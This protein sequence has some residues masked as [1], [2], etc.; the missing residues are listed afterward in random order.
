[1]FELDA[2]SFESKDNA[3]GW[4]FMSSILPPSIE[5][6]LSPVAGFFPLLFWLLKFGTFLLILQVELSSWIF[7]FR[8]FV[9]ARRSSFLETDF[10]KLLRELARLL[11]FDNRFTELFD[12]LRLAVL[13]FSFS[14]SFCF[15]F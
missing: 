8:V 6:R 13:A 1:M 12:F 14:S 4:I 5:F 10:D 3:M 2:N 11:E 9:L 15:I 7:L